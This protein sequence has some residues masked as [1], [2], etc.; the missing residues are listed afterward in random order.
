MR[1][2]AERYDSNLLKDAV[3]IIIE[4]INAGS[5]LQ[6]IL[7]SVSKNIQEARTLSKEMSAN[8]TTYAIFIGFAVIFG[9]PVLLALSKSILVVIQTLTAGLEV[10]AGISIPISVGSAS[11]A[12]RDFEIFSIVMI[13]LTSIMSSMITAMILK[14]NVKESPRYLSMIVPS[15]LAVYAIST[16]LLS[17]FVAA[18]VGQI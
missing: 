6:D 1:I 10:P 4:G 3:H 18:I 15:A 13:I 5:Q 11:I 16:F 2:F 17:F 14:G 12:I 7:N 8:V 9:S